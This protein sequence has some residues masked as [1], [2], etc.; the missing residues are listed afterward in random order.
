MT[1]NSI[2]QSEL[3]KCGLKSTKSRLAIINILNKSNQPISAEEIFKQLIN[4]KLTINLSTVY[5]TLDSFTEK[6]LVTK[7]S[8]MNDD[9][10]LFEYNNKGHRHHLICIGC[11]KIITIIKCPLHEYEKSLE[12]ETNFKIEAHKLYMYG[13]CQECQEKNVICS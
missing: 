3:K 11:K 6:N 8:I 4:D 7:I 12:Q 10:M 9:R 1:E 5:R 13:Y 2:F